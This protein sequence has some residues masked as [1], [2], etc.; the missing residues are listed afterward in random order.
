VRGSIAPGQENITSESGNA[1]ACVLDSSRRA[2]PGPA[3]EYQLRLRMK[4][5][6][7]RTTGFNMFYLL[8]GDLTARRAIIRRSRVG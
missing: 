8:A 7:S 5:P 2:Q 6:Q 1:D 3:T 4:D